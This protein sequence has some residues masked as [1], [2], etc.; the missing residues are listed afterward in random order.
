MAMVFR[1][2]FVR[3]ELG[4]TRGG[5]DKTIPPLAKTG[6]IR[7]RRFDSASGGVETP[8]PTNYSASCGQCLSTEDAELFLRS[9]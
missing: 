5:A 8:Q 1:N 2:I 4:G 7:L 3:S 9:L 6:G